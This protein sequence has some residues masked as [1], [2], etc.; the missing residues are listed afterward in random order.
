MPHNPAHDVDFRNY[1]TH[2][3]TVL[4]RIRELKLYLAQLEDVVKSMPHTGREAGYMDLDNIQQLHGELTELRDDLC[5]WESL[6]AEMDRLQ[7]DC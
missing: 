6:G 3:Q 7:V 5:D 4:R 1:A 2:R